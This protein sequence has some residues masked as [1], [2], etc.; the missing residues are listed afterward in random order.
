MIVCRSVRH[1]PDL[2]AITKAPSESSTRVK[3]LDLREFCYLETMNEEA[4]LTCG[5]SI[6][7]ISL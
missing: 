5:H 2:V 1:C 3:F 7:N 4:L 6:T